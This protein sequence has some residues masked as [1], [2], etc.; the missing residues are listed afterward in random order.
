[1]GASKPIEYKGKF[2]SSI[3]NLYEYL[4]V[5]ITYN[6]FTKA[7]KNG[8]N[9]D[10]IIKFH[11]IEYKGKI[12]KNVTRLAEENG[13][14]STTVM[15]RLRKGMSV[16]SAMKKK[17][18]IICFGEIY[19][20]LKSLAKKY[21]IN[22]NT[23]ISRINAGMSIEEAVTTKV[24]SNNIEFDYNGKHYSTLMEFA[25]EYNINYPRLSNRIL[26]GQD[27]KVAVKE[28]IE[29]PSK[30]PYIKRKLDHNNIIYKDIKY[31]SYKQLC[32]KLGIDYKFL[33]ARLSI[34]MSLEKAIEK[35]KI[36]KG[37]T[38]K[39]IKYK[40][41]KELCEKF[42]INVHTFKYRL[43]RGMS[44]ESALTCKTTG[45]GKCNNIVY[46]GKTYDKLYDLAKEY[47]INYGTFINRLNN[48]FSL[49]EAVEI[50][51]G[52][53]RSWYKHENNYYF[54]GKNYTNLQEISKITGINVNLIRTRLVN[55][56]DL[57]RAATQPKQTTSLS[58]KIIKYDG[59][60]YKNKRELA[61][62]Y[63]IDYQTLTGRLYRGWDLD[64][65][66]TTPI[67]INRF[68]YKGVDYANGRNLA[69]ALNMDEEFV[70][71]LSK[72]GYSAEEIA[73]M[74]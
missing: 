15:S 6:C 67:G 36:E 12:Y 60:I 47:N 52:I 11:N 53:R 3:K 31:N 61:E 13:M 2:Y 8:S 64:K 50:P 30:K 24:S 55:G 37:I 66:L 34:G 44:M 73:N 71:N 23:L 41:K 5:P 56:W 22:Y 49:E 33:L 68:E 9:I 19:S 14:A 28:C 40:S 25:K 69:K 65:A 59:K 21:N 46:K 7:I 10:E 62:K 57:E 32:E 1:M 26:R 35:P 51:I 17:D 45:S 20:S 70:L 74:K 18:T 58:E 27:I 29:N 72:R 39:G 4:N 54:R 42:G 48:G 16:E 63:N 38:Y 43:Q